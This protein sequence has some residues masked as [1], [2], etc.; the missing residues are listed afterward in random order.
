MLLECFERPLALTLW[1]VLLGTRFLTPTLGYLGV[2]GV[3]EAA[4]GVRSE[5]HD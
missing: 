4:L 1:E 3:H 5:R 2:L